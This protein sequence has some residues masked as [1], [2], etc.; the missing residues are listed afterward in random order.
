MRCQ[1]VRSY[2]SAYCNDEL[3]GRKKQVID[4]HLSNC[5]GCRKEEAI[6]YSLSSSRND[7]S[8]LTVSD[9]FNTK[10]LNRIA[11]ERFAETRTR[12]YQPKNAP[13]FSWA[14][15]VPAVASAFVVVLVAFSVMYSGLGQ[16]SQEMAVNNGHL[17][18]SYRTVQPTNNPNMTVNLHKN[19]SLDNQLARN[20]RV[21][22]ISNTMTKAGSF[23]GQ[24]QQLLTATKTNEQIQIPYNPNYYQVRKVFRVYI[25]PQNNSIEG[26]TEEY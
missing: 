11:R 6:F 3:S 19:W 16:G 20:E 13:S 25:I 4:E 21:N 14:K 17:D 7:L 18:E 26:G 2:L 15:V 9:D 10:L 24:S 22:T 23:S 5:A 1:K 12:A 8:Q